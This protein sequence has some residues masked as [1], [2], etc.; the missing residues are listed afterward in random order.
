MS[1]P[2]PAILVVDDN[3]ANLRVLDSILTSAGY[4]ILPALGGEIALRAAGTVRPELALLDVRMP[5]MDGYEVCRRLKTTPGLEQMPVI[6]ISA[7]T[8]TE[9]KVRAFHAGGVDYI[10]KPFQTDE[11]LSRV[12][13]HID[14]SRSRRELAQAKGALEGLVAERTAALT[15]SNTRLELAMRHEQA[16]RQLLTL[17]LATRDLNDYL[18]AGLERLSEVFGWTAPLHKSA[19]F[20]TEGEGAGER[21]ERVASIGMPSEQGEPC[22]EVDFDACL[23]GAAA[24][25]GQLQQADAHDCPAGL[26]D[27]AHA[28]R[29]RIALPLITG[30]RCLGVLMHATTGEAPIAEDEVRLLQQVADVLTMSIARRYSEER[31]AYLAY[32]DELTGL[33]NRS[34]FNERL[35]LELQRTMRHPSP[36]A[37]LFIDIDHFKQINDVLGHST[38]DAYL[39]TSAKRLAKALR[40][41][42]LLCRWGSDEFAVLSLE[43]GA[44]VEC[45]GTDAQTIAL[46]L[47]EVLA[48]PLSLAGHEIQLNASIGIALHPWDGSEATELLQH[49]EL[50]MSRAKQAGRNQLHFYQPEM[51]T[52]AVRRM[53]LGRELRRALDEGQFVVHYQPQVSVDG[54]L[55]GAEALVRWNHPQR[56]LVA[57]GEFIP[58]AEELGLIVPLGDWVLAQSV[59]WLGELAGRMGL[60]QLSVNVSARQFHEAGFAE[61]CLALLAGAGVSPQHVELEVTESL[62]LADIEGAHHK[63]AALHEAGLSIAVDY[64]GTGYSSL[65]YLRRLPVQKL[66]IDRVFVDGVH[67]DARNAAI[68]HTIIALARNL[69]LCTIAEGVEREEE[70]VFLRQ[71]GCDA[72]QGF[73]FGR[74]VAPDEFARLWF[75]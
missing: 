55:S 41:G 46:K 50:A 31:I 61:R 27:P 24:A 57:P 65:A 43:L 2:P 71:A 40:A 38:G 66:K 70:V 35:A 52:E 59:R 63:I 64:F 72:F 47:A 34:A 58:L 29:A 22:H 17:S 74:P 11:V 51:Q 75:G 5:G 16:L 6:F 48:R 54:A 62:L 21:L 9:D 19:I 10:T 44:G 49:A 12:R 14:L 26:L 36:F 20:L 30:E 60:P 15:A 53:T 67:Q 56:G 45:A 33:W 1:L 69:G 18:Q 32:H 39:A 73:Y 7:L 25:T 23:C 3:P 68:V 28:P 42:D 13:T 4:R 37:V 8:E